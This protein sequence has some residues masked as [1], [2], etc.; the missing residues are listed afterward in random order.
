M[1]TIYKDNS[2]KDSVKARGDISSRMAVTMKEIS[3]IMWPMDMENSSIKLATDMKANGRTI[4]PMVGVKPYILMRAVTMENFSIIEGMEVESSCRRNAFSRGTSQTTNWKGPLL[5]K[6]KMEK[7][8]QANGNKMR[9]MERELTVG[10][11]ETNT[12]ANTNLERDQ[13][14]A[15][16]PTQMENFTKATGLMEL[17]KEMEPIK[18]QRPV[19]EESGEK[20]NL[21]KRKIDNFYNLFVTIF[22]S[23]K[24]IYSKFDCSSLTKLS[25]AK[26][27]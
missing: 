17:K 19:Y 2:S 9:N 21:L 25:Q 22:N 12:K 3:G 4:S 23:T 1:E 18:L 20:G 24:F 10:Q 7:A 16:C 26:F 14:S 11:M 8:T 27:I 15:L 5:C 13:D 6:I